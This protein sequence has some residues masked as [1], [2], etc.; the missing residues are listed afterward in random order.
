MNKFDNYAVLNLAQTAEYL[1]V[2][3]QTIYNYVKNGVLP[4]FRAKGSGNYRFFKS[5]IDETLKKPFK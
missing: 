4:Y 5:K 1:Q 3:K 2:S